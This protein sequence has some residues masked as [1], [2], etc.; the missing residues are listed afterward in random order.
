MK[1]TPQVWNPKQ[2]AR[3][4]RYVAKLAL[5]SITLL[6]PQPEEHILALGCSNG[7]LILHIASTGAKVSGI[8]ASLEQV[9]ATRS[10]G[11]AACALILFMLALLQPFVRL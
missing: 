2:Y 10:R 7:F 5:P 11:L 8:D 3:D 4:A 1:P 6:A 9:V